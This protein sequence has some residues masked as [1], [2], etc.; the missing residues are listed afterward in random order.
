[1]KTLTSSLGFLAFIFGLLAVVRIAAGWYF[2]KR[3]QRSAS[4]PPIEDTNVRIRIM[5]RKWMTITIKSFAVI[6]AML[7]I[8]AI[9]TIL[10]PA[11]N[12]PVSG[13]LGIYSTEQFYITRQCRD[14]ML[15]TFA[16]FPLLVFLPCKHSGLRS[17]IWG[18]AA[19]AEILIIGGILL[20]L[21]FI[22]ALA[23]GGGSFG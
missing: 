9:P 6:T 7:G 19:L 10:V 13:Q 16:L 8:Y 20:F 5:S 22:L 18:V 14:F 1:M 15:I 2:G 11:F 21:L 12:V 23:F 17:L 3:E 4:V